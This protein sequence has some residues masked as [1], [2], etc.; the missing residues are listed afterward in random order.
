MTIVETLYASDGAPMGAGT[1]G[2]RVGDELFIG[3]YH[4]D[5]ILR[6]NLKER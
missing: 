6:V 5:R 2:L 1:V 3:S 4:G